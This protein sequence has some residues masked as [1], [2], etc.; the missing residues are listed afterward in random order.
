MA[1]GAAQPESPPPPGSTVPVSAVPVSAVPGPAVPGPASLVSSVTATIALETPIEQAPGITPKLGESI[2]ELGIR[3]VGQLV[4]YLPFRHEREEAESGMDQIAAGQIVSV[5]GTIEATR[6]V[7]SAKSRFE[8]VLTDGPNRLD[9]VWF[10][11]PYL[12]DKLHPGLRVRVQ[13]KVN[14]RMG[15]MQIT[16]AKFEVI[17]ETAADPAMRD[18]RF[19][20][21]Y[22]ASEACSSIQIERAVKSVLPL[23]LPLIVDHFDEAYRKPREL[24]DLASAYAQM[25]QPESEEQA[26]RARRR[27]AYDEL[28]L[29]QLGLAATRLERSGGAR[30]PVLRW[31]PVLDTRIRKRFPFELT[32]AQT[33]VVKEIAADL[34]KPEPA[35]RLIQ[36]DVGSGKT[37]VALYAM[38][39]AVASGHQ[40]ALM[41]P[42]EILAEQHAASIGRLLK[43]SEVRV[44]LL[45]GALKGAARREATAAIASGEVDLVIGTHAVIGQG[46]KFASLAV[47]V[48]D[49]QHR[50]G[51][52]QRAKLRAKGESADLVPHTLVMTATPIPRTLAMTLFGDL[53]VS[54]ID[55]LPPGRKPVKT[56]VVPPPLAG[57]VYSWVRERVEKGEQAFVVAPAIEPGDPDDGTSINGPGSLASVKELHERLGRAELAGKRLDVM[58]GQMEQ[59]ERESVMDRFRRGEIDVLIAT[60]VIEVG[61]D[62]ANATVIVVE[63]AERF[64][65]AQLHQLR[66]RVGRG[67]KPGAC[68]LIATPVTPQSEA[69][70]ATL[71]A[72][73]DGFKLAEKD[74]EIRGFGDVLGV[75][76]SGMPPFKVADLSKDLDLLTMARRDAMAMVKASPKLDKPE[77]ALLKR[78]LLRAHGKWLGLG[79]VA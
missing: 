71:A 38:L 37:A 79:E 55:K 64:G 70:L 34:T 35:N 59:H 15:M 40:A 30:A 21:V 43:G 18:L 3:S 17:R 58:H 53:D 1:K 45:T 27:L 12:K 50:F 49:E 23:A 13:G 47:V 67:S 28:F 56:R 62:V 51:V 72:T 26:K 48:I 22:P 36:G 78:R 65:L 73:T 76:Q 31:A 8:A 25:H 46:V 29:L 44:Q 75:R 33:A 63:H 24:P 61:V 69:R 19:R 2:R 74:L 39:M 57:E 5:R 54:T 6:L 32:D 7:R 68:I 11:Q 16:G 14:A 52:H 4:A 42:T 60:T 20:P 9:L 66:G 77:L 41:V 10:N